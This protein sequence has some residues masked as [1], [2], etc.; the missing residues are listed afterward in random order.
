[1]DIKAFNRK[2]IILAV[3]CA[4]GF[5]CA[6]SYP[7]RQH[8]FGQYQVKVMVASFALAFLIMCF[9]GPTLEETQEYH[10]QMIKNEAD[11]DAK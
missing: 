2:R 7:F 6:I 11:K 8:L 9:N 1:V 4:P 10:D 5:F 3:A